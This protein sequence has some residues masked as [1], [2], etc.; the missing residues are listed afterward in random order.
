MKTTKKLLSL[1]TSV[2]ILS[3]FFSINTNAQNTPQLT[4]AEIASVAVTANAIDVDYAG[5]AWKKEISG[6]VMDFAT[7]MRNDH[8]AIIGMAVDLANKLGVTPKMNPVTKSLLEGA[9]KTKKKL[10]ALSGEAFEK[11]YVDNEVAYH[12]AVINAVKNVL[13][14]QADNQQLKDLLKK[15]MPILKGHLHHAKMI[16]KE[17]N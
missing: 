8:N 3:L 17:I 15:A 11:A 13:I 9:E 12:K 10:N 16:Q 1:T 5:I 2:L 7:N 4:D 6:K 14:P